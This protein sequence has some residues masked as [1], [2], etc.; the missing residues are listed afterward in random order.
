MPFNGSGTFQPV[1]PPDYPAVAGTI[2]RA[3]QFNAVVNDLMYNGLTN[4]ITRDGQS[5][6]SANLPMANFRHTGVGAATALTQ[7]ARMDQVVGGG[8]SQ[9]AG[10][11]GGTADALTLTLPV[12]P[13]LTAGLTIAF[14]A[15]ATNT[16]AA[17]IDVNGLGA[18]AV[19]TYYG[20]ALP[21]AHF[22]TGQMYTI[23]YDGTNFVDVTPFNRADPQTVSGAWSFTGAVEFTG[24][25]TFTGTVGF[26]GTTP[27]GQRPA[28]SLGVNYSPARVLGN[29]LTSTVGW[30]GTGTATG[31]NTSPPD[32]SAAPGTATDL[33]DDLVANT[34]PPIRNG[35]YTLTQQITNAADDIKSL[36][37]VVA[38]ITNDLKAFGLTA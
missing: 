15:S 9:W 34:L 30:A 5:P 21:A 38:Q 37:E 8:S 22:V 24:A 20:A 25:A 1:A 16:G 19:E 18:T 3:D 17:T 23:R 28:Y 12:A 31:T 35:L 33:R 11:A 36:K 32:P 26:F 2:I 13:T 6:P 14:A 29:L 27:V 7:Y 10:A 4:C